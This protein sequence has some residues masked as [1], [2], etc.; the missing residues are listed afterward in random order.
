PH[1]LFGEVHRGHEDT[2]AHPAAMPEHPMLR[3]RVS[4]N[5]NVNHLPAR[6]NPAARNLAPAVRALLGRMLYYLRRRFP[7]ANKRLGPLLALLLGLGRLV[8]LDEGGN[9]TGNP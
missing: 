6:M 4:H 1:N 2:P 8:R 3:H 9:R 5:R 7:M